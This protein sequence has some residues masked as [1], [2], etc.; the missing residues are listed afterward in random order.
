MQNSC[1]KELPRLPQRARARACTHASPASLCRQP[2]AAAAASPAPC[3]FRRFQCRHSLTAL[4]QSTLLSGLLATVGT[5]HAARRMGTA[6][7]G[8]SSVR[9]LPSN[10]HHACARLSAGTC[11]GFFFGVRAGGEGV[12]CW[13]QVGRGERGLQ[14]KST[15]RQ[16]AAA[17][18]GRQ[19]RNRRRRRAGVQARSAP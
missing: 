6:S 5:G 19:Q 15:A 3:T 10:E 14:K 2:R 9:S 17:A 8:R 4:N 16:Q 13:V 7:P 18:G 1:K 11:E 12:R